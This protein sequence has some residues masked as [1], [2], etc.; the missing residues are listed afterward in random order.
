MET[1]PERTQHEA[2]DHFWG[3]FQPRMVYLQQFKIQMKQPGLK[4]AELVAQYFIIVLRPAPSPSPRVLPRPHVFG[5]IAR[6]ISPRNEML[7]RKER[8]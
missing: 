4:L 7:Q 5:E 3:P 8:V 6:I 1:A 2:I